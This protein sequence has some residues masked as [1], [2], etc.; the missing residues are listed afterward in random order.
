MS[1]KLDAMHASNILGF[2]Q[3]RSCKETIFAAVGAAPVPGG[4][5]FKWHCDLC[6]HRFETVETIEEEAAA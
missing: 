4:V 3:C 5:L 6:D 1:K 2:Q